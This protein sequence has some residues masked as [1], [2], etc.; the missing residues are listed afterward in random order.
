MVD[1]LGDYFNMRTNS[2]PIIAFVEKRRVV[3]RAALG[4][5]SGIIFV[6]VMDAGPFQNSQI[7]QF[8]MTMIVVVSTNRLIRLQPTGQVDPTYR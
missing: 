1:Q 2:A 3:Q 4:F 7:L 6:A 8:L 5:G